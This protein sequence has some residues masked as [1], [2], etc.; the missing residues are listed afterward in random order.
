MST[1]S[2]RIGRMSS[3][4]CSDRPSANRRDGSFTVGRG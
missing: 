1:R 4:R 3:C 2:S